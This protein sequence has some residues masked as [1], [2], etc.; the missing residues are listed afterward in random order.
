MK[1]KLCEVGER[2]VISP[3]GI[4]LGDLGVSILHPF[5]SR[6]LIGRAGRGRVL[7]GRLKDEESH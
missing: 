1:A 3:K 4:E 5:E 7:T 2:P 6:S